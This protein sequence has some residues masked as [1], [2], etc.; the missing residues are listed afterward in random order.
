MKRPFILNIHLILSAVFIPLL[1]IIPLSG[2]LYL[3][4]L[5]G[6]QQKTEVLSVEATLPSDMKGKEDALRKILADNKIDY[7]FEYIKETPSE[8][9]LRPTS[10]DYYTAVAK[11]GKITLFAVKPSFTAKLMELHKG[12]GPR[13]MKY[14]EAA[15]G[16]SM[17]L[18]L[19]SGLWLALTIP[20]YRKI[21]LISGA[22]GIVLLGAL[23]I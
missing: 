21:T 7:N 4:G 8:L 14:F 1:L 10:R 12:H 16:I 17:I 23:L 19:L 3:L 15:F 13:M 18:V 6:D 22:I 5:K 11:E 9:I 2:S 20:K